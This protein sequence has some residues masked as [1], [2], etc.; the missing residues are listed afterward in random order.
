MKKHFFRAVFLCLVMFHIAAA[1]PIQR[2]IRVSYFVTDAQIG[3][4]SAAKLTIDC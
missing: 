3:Y 1:Q 2:G 4:Y